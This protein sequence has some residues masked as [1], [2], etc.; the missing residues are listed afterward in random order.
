MCRVG[1]GVAGGLL[2][3]GAAQAA[4]G[5]VERGRLLYQGRCSACHAPDYH[6]VGPLHRGVFGRGAGKAPGYDYS[7]ALKAATLTWDDASLDRWLAD[8]E[9]LLPGQR[10]GVNVP[11]AAERADLIAYLKSLAPRQSLR[12]E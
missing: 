9:R 1:F 2:M 3:L 8:P 4:A 10:M 11:D 5:D 6:G 7:P 12:K